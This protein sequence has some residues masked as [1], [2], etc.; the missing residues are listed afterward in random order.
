MTNERSAGIRKS[1]N[2]KVREHLEAGKSIT[3]LAALHLYGCL[4]LGA[5]I[6]D[7]RRKQGLPIVTEIVKGKGG[8]HY[9]SYSL[10]TNTPGDSAE[11]KA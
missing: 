5:R 8:K 6:W 4:R 1:Q 10:Q 2:E 7:L 3:P 9:A 11:G